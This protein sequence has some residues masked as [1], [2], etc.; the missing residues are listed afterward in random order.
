ML[1]LP[2]CS[3][4]ADCVRITGAIR[5][6]SSLTYVGGSDTAYEF[7]HITIMFWVQH[8]MPM[9]RHGAV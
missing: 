7:T 5:L 8:S 3:T 2:A 9:I 1:T 4:S 6:H